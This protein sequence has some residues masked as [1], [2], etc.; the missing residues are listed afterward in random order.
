MLSLA[1]TRMRIRYRGRAIN[2]VKRNFKNSHTDDINCR[3]CPRVPNKTVEDHL[4]NEINPDQD[5]N[6]SDET[7]EHL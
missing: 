5:Q 2:G 7:Q 4:E 6:Y 3:F 1:G